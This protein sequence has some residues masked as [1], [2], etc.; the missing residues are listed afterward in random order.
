MHVEC[1]WNRSSNKLLTFYN[2]QPSLCNIRRLCIYRR[3]NLQRA[4]TF[5]KVDT[6]KQSYAKGRNSLPYKL[7]TFDSSQPN[8]KKKRRT[9]CSFGKEMSQTL[10]ISSKPTKVGYRVCIINKEDQPNES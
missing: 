9:K 3:S 4:T 7:R 1:S 6:L 5:R 2:Q 8:S 10:P